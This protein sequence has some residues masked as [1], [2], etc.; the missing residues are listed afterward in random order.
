MS[1]FQWT[2]DDVVLGPEVLARRRWWRRAWRWLQNKWENEMKYFWRRHDDARVRLWRED[3]S[4]DVF[5]VLSIRDF[6]SRCLELQDDGHA[7]LAVD[8]D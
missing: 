6:Q 8:E 5:D 3:D 1:K 4:G 2:D 7:V